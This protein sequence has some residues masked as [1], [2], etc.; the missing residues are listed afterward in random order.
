MTHVWVQLN[1]SYIYIYNYALVVIIW[2]GWCSPKIYIIRRVV[3][4]K[5]NNLGYANIKW[6]C[7]FFIAQHIWKVVLQYENMT[8]FPTLLLAYRTSVQ[9]TTGTTPFQLMF[10][11]NLHL[12]EDVLYSLPITSYD[13]VTQYTKVLKGHLQRSY[14]TVNK[15]VQQQQIHQKE[16][17]DHG[18]RD[19]PYGVGDLVLLHSSAVPR[20]KS[21]K[22]H[23]PWQGPYRVVKAISP[24]VYHIVDCAS[25][26]C[27]HVVHFNCLKHCSWWRW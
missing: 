5:P 6:F 13:L 4:D 19:S 24:S 21:R 18:V 9:E 14:Q 23:K 2:S 20:G 8:L 22:L 27:K 25:P 15:R 1:L 3:F 17:Y 16:V 7:V 11:C 10:G 12:P 26:R